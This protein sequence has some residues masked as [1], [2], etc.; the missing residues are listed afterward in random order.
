[1]VPSSYT[2]SHTSSHQAI[3]VINHNIATIAQAVVARL[4][5][6]MYVPINFLQDAL[7]L[8]KPCLCYVTHAGTVT[9]LFI[10]VRTGCA[11]ALPNAGVSKFWVANLI[12][13][14]HGAISLGVRV[15]LPLKESRACDFSADG[16]TERVAAEK[17][18]AAICHRN[19]TAC[20]ISWR[21]L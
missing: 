7:G 10:G 3:A 12:D 14:S 2:H 20:D 4:S 5:C 13:V 1:M 11:Q 21:R 8:A 16:K 18:H 17:E 6:T 15:E 9:L 19:T